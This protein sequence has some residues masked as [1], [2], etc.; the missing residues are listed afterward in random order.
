LA[1]QAVFRGQLQTHPSLLQLFSDPHS[2]P[3]EEALAACRKLGSA[4]SMHRWISLPQN[5][6]MY[7]E[8]FG[9]GAT[10][11]AA[12]EATRVA[13]E[14]EAAHEAAKKAAQSQAALLAECTAEG[15]GA[16]LKGVFNA[17]LWVHRSL[18]QTF[19]DPQS[20]PVKTAIN[21]C[22]AGHDGGGRGGLARWMTKPENKKWY[23]D[24]A[25]IAAA[26]Q[27]AADAAHTAAE[28]EAANKAAQA[29]ATKLAQCKPIAATAALFTAFGN[30][31]ATYPSLEMMFHDVN[32]SAVK[33]AIADCQAGREGGGRDGIRL[34]IAKP[35]TKKRYWDTLGF[36]TH[37]LN[38][39]C[40]PSQI[41]D[42]LRKLFQQEVARSPALTAYFADDRSPLVVYVRNDVCTG[43]LQQGFAVGLS[44]LHRHP[45]I[46]QWYWTSFLVQ[47]AKPD[48]CTASAAKDVLHAVFAPELK[49]HPVF[50]QVFADAHSQ[51]V[52]AAINDCLAGREG[53]GRDGMRKWLD[54]AEVRKH[55]WDRFGLADR[56]RE[57]DELARQ[58]AVR[59]EARRRAETCSQGFY[60]LDGTNNG[61]H[62]ATIMYHLY[63]WAW[64]QP[65]CTL[66]KRYFAGIGDAIAGIGLVT[67]AGVDEM[68]ADAI[69]AI[70]EDAAGRTPGAP[71]VQ[72]IGV[73]GFSRGAM[74]AL[75][76]VNH[77]GKTGCPGLGPLGARIVFLGLDDAVRTSMDGKWP[78]NLEVNVP[79]RI[80]VIKTQ[81]QTPHPE[82]IA[83]W[84]H[85]VGGIHE[86]IELEQMEHVDMN[87]FRK[88]VKTGPLWDVK[89]KEVDVGNA[90]RVK[91]ILLGYAQRAGLRFAPSENQGVLGTCP[92]DNPGAKNRL[93]EVL[94]GNHSW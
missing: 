27:A 50:A 49:S 37:V 46:K 11:Q 59:E 26:V 5:K 89:L 18:A 58:Q 4:K 68:K 25:G 14:Q 38:N 86:T 32:S 1:L 9:I 75:A 55:Y 23:W 45:K 10:A 24:N 36:Q 83:L 52:K 61:S 41:Q 17:E 44:D 35:E 82:R 16:V 31:V 48:E 87:C 42:A 92:V 8:T 93:E 20:Q 12:A 74:V 81:Y 21:D 76:V 6:K 13:A 53:G 19:S 33:T 72:Q 40:R 88:Q 91:D 30:E 62:Q 28:Q 67:G 66:V 78:D 90:G 2:R 22:R 64:A 70:C 43:N 29:Q 79:Y 34:W 69:K 39:E 84:T 73:I 54:R 60:V 47:A 7:W 94:K 65:S 15:V 71:P 77:L 51:P 56:A 63:K 80:Q 57:A 3:V 85:K